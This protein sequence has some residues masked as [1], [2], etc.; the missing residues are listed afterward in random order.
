M[1]L[2]CFQSRLNSK[3]KGRAIGLGNLLTTSLMLCSEISLKETVTRGMHIFVFVNQIKGVVG[4][5][6]EPLETKPF[7]NL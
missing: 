3:R 2:C 7:T 4:D 1:I 5:V 6:A